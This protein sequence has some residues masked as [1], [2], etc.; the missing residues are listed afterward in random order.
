MSQDKTAQVMAH[1]A[2]HRAADSKFASPFAYAA[3]Q[4]RRGEGWGG[5]GWGGAPVGARTLRRRRQ[6][7]MPCCVGRA[8]LFKACMATLHGS[9]LACIM[10][11]ASGIGGGSIGAAIARHACDVI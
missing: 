7:G 3:F 8:S 5:W 1:Y 11:S 4:V 6:A 10:Y 9:L 2:R